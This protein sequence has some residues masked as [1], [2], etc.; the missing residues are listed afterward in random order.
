MNNRRRILVALG[1]GTITASFASVAQQKTKVWRIGFL[2]SETAAG[3]VP[4][5]D[6]FRASLKELG[7]VEGRNVVFLYRW[8][9]GMP[10]R[11]PQLA[12]EL[13][14]LRAAKVESADVPA[15]GRL[16]VAD[17]NDVETAGDLLPHRL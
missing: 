4:Q 17:T 15:R 16:V 13:L 5:L 12:D 2:G 11:L 9:E 7:Y 14:L 8:A 10:E 6:T 1:G 3:Y